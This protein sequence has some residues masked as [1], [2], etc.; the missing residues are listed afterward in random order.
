M[1]ARR[2]LTDVQQG[3]CAQQLFTSYGT[4]ASRGQIEFN[5]ALTDDERRDFEVHI[6]GEYVGIAVQVK[7]ALNVYHGRSTHHRVEYLNIRFP[8]RTTRID[9]DPRFWYFLTGFDLPKLGLRVP[10]FLVPAVEIHKHCRYGPVRKG[11]VRITFL[12][13]L[14]DKSHD[15]WVRYRVAR[16]GDLGSKLEAA[17]RTLPRSMRMDRDLA[18]QLG[19][20]R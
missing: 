9:N 15:R 16:L 10:M 6:R 2:G 4:L 17:I 13:S 1:T 19:A 7:S 18:A 5:P 14:E 3:I 20:L 8:I 12:A 11:H